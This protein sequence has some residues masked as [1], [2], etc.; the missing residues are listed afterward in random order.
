MTDRNSSL[1]P[2]SGA[3]HYGYVI[4]GVGLLV[5]FACLGLARFSLGI[6]LPSMSEALGMSY[7]QRGYLGT[8][9]FIGYLAM[10]AGAPAL[11]KRLGNR[12]A[13][14]FGLGLIGATMVS[15]G[16]AGAFI[17][18]LIL[19]TFTGVG[20]GAANI[21]M[22]ALVSNWFAPSARGTATGAVIAGNG[23]GIILSGI[24]VPAVVTS[25]DT[26]GWRWGWIVLGGL[27]LG[28]CLAAGALL[29]NS[30]EDKGLT[31]FGNGG[32]GPA[33]TPPRPAALALSQEEK[34]FLV[35]LGAIYSL[36]GTTYIIYG[37]FFVTTLVDELGLG[38]EAA[39]RF[40]SWVGFFSLFSGP[41]FG[42]ISDSL[43]R[44]AGLMAAFSVQTCAYLL[45]GFHGQLHSAGLVSVYL[46]LYGSVVLFGLAAWSIPTIMTATV[47]DRL[48]PARTALGFSFITFFFA[49][50]QVVG[51]TGA[52]ALGEVTGSFTMAYALSA[53]LTLM[54]AGLASLL[55]TRR[56]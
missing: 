50:G 28:I 39:G 19:Y 49:V 48:G 26:G 55:P 4:M 2:P 7:A 6:L 21:S 25:F 9:Y 34:R 14:V 38:E 5:M 46:S 35:H 52:G 53:I 16:I 43:G 22:M 15:L 37:T 1:E 40:W 56:S 31:M 12:L 24:L 3:L 13:I 23:A 29:R 51:P 30:P 42:R 10:V 8:G 11:S 17:P 47:A 44:R 54:G 36:F 45:A 41:L 32:K 27:A 18:A 20:S 33:A